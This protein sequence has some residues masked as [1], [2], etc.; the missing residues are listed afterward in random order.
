MMDGDSKASIV[1]ALLAEPKGVRRRLVLG[2]TTPSDI[3]GEVGPAKFKSRTEY[4]RAL[5]DSQSG[6]QRAHVETV[7]SNLSQYVVVVHAYA[8]T[9]TVVVEG[10][11]SQLTRA[12][13]HACVE[14]ASFDEEITLI[15]PLKTDW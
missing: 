7:A 12:L 6:A 4:R 10:S 2:L 13:N 14:T 3:P 1:S 15:E 11:A 5:I 8:L 9:N